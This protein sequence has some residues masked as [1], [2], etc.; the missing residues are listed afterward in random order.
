MLICLQD[1]QPALYS[2]EAIL[3]SSIEENDI[4]E[5]L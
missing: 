5:L 1:V 4:A 3:L 2:Y